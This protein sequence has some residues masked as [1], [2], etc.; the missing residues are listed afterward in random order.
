MAR[1]N[2]IFCKIFVCLVFK[3]FVAMPFCYASDLGTAAELKAGRQLYDK[4][5]VQCHGEKGD[6][7]TYA[8]AYFKPRP[9]DF[10]SG[11]YK[12]RH[13]RN[14]ELPLDEDLRSA[15][16]NGLAFK[17]GMAYTTMPPWPKLREQE[18]TNLVYY[19][20]TFSSD[21]ADPNY[22]NP[23]RIAIPKPLPITESSLSKG[24]V[25]Y[26]ENE[27]AKCHGEFGRGDG[28]SAPTLKDD[29][30]QH[31]KPADLTKRWTFRGGGSQTDIFRTISTGFNGTPMPS[32]AD[33]VSEED[34]L[35]LT[36]YI[37]SMSPRENA[38]YFPPNKPILVTYVEEDIENADFDSL[39]TLL[40]TSPPA[41]IPIVGQ[42]IEIGREFFPS[43][44]EVEV[45]G[46]Y[47]NTDVAMMV[48]WHDIRADVSGNNAPDISVPLYVA[49]VDE[50]PEQISGDPFS[51]IEVDPFAGDEF[52]PFAEDDYDDF[53]SKYSDAIAIQLPKSIPTSLVKPYFL[54]GDE[55]NPVDLW[56][57][58]LAKK[59]AIVYEGRG[60]KRLK[61][62]EEVKVRVNAEFSDGQWIVIFQRKIELENGVDFQE[63][64]FMPVSFSVWDGFNEE[65]GSK[66][67]I[68]SWYYLYF[69]PK[70]KPSVIV[71]ML[72]YGLIILILEIVLVW[73][74][75][76]KSRS[77]M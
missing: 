22:N 36:N 30:G 31:I 69:E 43:A 71:P 70:E 7:Q 15:I 59:Q 72:Q 1:L 40:H 23:K 35:H 51:D 32:Y 48:K 21:F 42:V 60:S 17:Q 73:Y 6:G 18:V 66:R 38:D 44:N 11:K 77:K 49:T 58:D 62:L 47:N 4:H 54:F 76:R 5:C 74:I 3:C 10:T 27:C 12:I 29:G 55:R 20:K 14:G 13:T 39:K 68:S 41:F 64:S 33:S 9:R 52:D 8:S 24:K 67:G 61:P 63:D 19:I 50:E 26:Q 75:R 2:I 53:E 65:R 37:F 28:P 56:F 46:V 57:T 45:H 34:R 25:V 16:V